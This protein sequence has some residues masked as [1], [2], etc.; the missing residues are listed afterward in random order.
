MYRT[1]TQPYDVPSKVQIEELNGVRV[2][3]ALAARWPMRDQK[4]ETTCGSVRRPGSR[5]QSPW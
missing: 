3:D 2:D 5:Q 4:T 1:R